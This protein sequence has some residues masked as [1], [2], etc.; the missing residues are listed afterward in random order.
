[1]ACAPPARYRV[2]G[3]E[4]TVMR[5]TVLSLVFAMT[6]AC[7]GAS[8]EPKAPATE[9]AD[10]AAAAPDPTP[11]SIP[12][13]PKTEPVKTSAVS[14]TADGSDIVPPFTASSSDDTKPAAPAPPAKTKKAKSK[15]K[16]KTQ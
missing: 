1:V 12:D 8:P 4:V 7:G 2:I 3:W 11:A 16:K 15:A 9:P 5:T 10:P 13:P 6:V 14:N